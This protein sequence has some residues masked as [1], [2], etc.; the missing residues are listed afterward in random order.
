MF[1]GFANVWTPVELSK[2]VGRKRPVRVVIAGE[3]IVL[4]RGRD[5][6]VA[7]LID[8]CPH[9]GV[10]LS[11]GS[12]TAEGRLECPFHGWQFEE[13]GACAHIP[14][15]DLP[16]D[17]R[18]RM[19]ALGLPVREVSGLIWLF[20]GALREDAPSVTGA[21]T[22]AVTGT[23]AGTGTSAGEPA[24]PEMLVPGAGSSL[25]IH[26]ETWKTHWTRVM[27]NMLDFP[28]L[29]FIHRRTI[30]RQLRAS[31]KSGS[32]LKLDWEP[33]E[34]GALIRASFDGEPAGA[35]LEWRRPNGMVLRL[36]PP[37]GKKM[38]MHLYCVPIDDKST[39]LILVAARNFWRNPVG[40]LFDQ[41]NRLILLEDR[42]IVESSD[43]PEVPP[44]GDELSVATD[45]PTLAFRR[46]YYREL[47]GRGAEDLVSA[48]SLTRRGGAPASPSALPLAS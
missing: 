25:W 35:A 5:G 21:V 38:R 4:F 39:R 24:I 45:G 41:F 42:S 19:R 40:K 34:T 23:N 27:E 15:C 13:S 36:D 7:A 33:N 14:Y 2:R 28:H 48:R 17:K 11:L 46:Y 22:G 32:T 1:N 18:S 10:S 20:T 6:R 9:R 47:R 30:G 31:L 29:P 8:R 3:A 43:P 26:A 37:G 12:I 44:A 16:A